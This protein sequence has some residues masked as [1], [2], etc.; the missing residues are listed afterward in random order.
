MTKGADSGC[1]ELCHGSLYIKWELEIVSFERADKHLAVEVVYSRASR[2]SV[3]AHVCESTEVH[4]G[5]S[6]SLVVCEVR[7]ELKW[8]V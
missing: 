5:R 1:F 8:I 7:R 4:R 3:A 6:H 2:G